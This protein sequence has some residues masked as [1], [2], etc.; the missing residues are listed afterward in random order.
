MELQCAAV[1]VQGNY[2]DVN[3]FETDGACK[4]RM[5]LQSIAGCP[6]QCITNNGANGQPAQICNGNGVCG[7]DSD[8]AYTKCFCYS[9]W[10]G[11]GCTAAVA[12]PKGVSVEGGLLIAVC[13]VLAGVIFM[14]GYMFVKLRKLQIDPAA[15]SELEGR[16]NE[17]G[18]V[19]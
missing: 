1:A 7:Y 11:A 15:Y 9:G 12:P 3:V 18:M 14:T 19:A 2:G 13:V 5:I 17:L 16:F 6:T 4:Y 10:G 8:N